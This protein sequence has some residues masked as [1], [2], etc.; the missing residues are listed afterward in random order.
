MNRP[1]NLAEFLAEFRCVDPDTLEE[2]IAGYFWAQRF[3]DYLKVSP[4]EN[5]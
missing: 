5:H 1:K 3:L 4:F 2:S